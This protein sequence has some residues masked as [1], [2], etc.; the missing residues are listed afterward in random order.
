MRV[1][2]SGGEAFVAKELLDRTQVRP[3]V[4]H[5]SGKRVPNDMRTLFLNFGYLSDATLHKSRN[6]HRVDPAAART[7]EKRRT[8]T[9]LVLAAISQISFHRTGRFLPKRED[10][11]FPPLAPHSHRSVLEVYIFFAQVHQR[12]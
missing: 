9:F 11:L 2:L 4:Q 7:Q 1:D 8:R 5:M 10:P 3:P 12:S 6:R